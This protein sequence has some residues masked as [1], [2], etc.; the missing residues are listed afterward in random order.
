MKNMFIDCL[1]NKMLSRDAPN[2]TGLARNIIIPRRKN[3]HVKSENLRPFV[4]LLESD[5][6]GTLYF[7]ARETFVSVWLL[8][9]LSIGHETKKKK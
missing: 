4:N 3:E 1:K 7:G 8:S 6:L 2:S 9:F 5:M